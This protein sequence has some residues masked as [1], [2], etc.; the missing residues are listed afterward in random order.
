MAHCQKP[1]TTAGGD[2]LEFRSPS[3]IA[4]RQDKTRMVLSDDDPQKWDYRIHTRAKHGILSRYIKAWLAILSYDARR[5]GRPA[6]LTI[7]DGFA[8]RGRYNEGEEGS[9]VIFR[10]VAEQVISQGI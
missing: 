4:R 7:V 1:V 3:Q 8:G 6:H 5:S 2:V 10:R 9:P